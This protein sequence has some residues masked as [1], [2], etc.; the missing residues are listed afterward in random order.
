MEDKYEGLVKGGQGKDSG[1]VVQSAF[2][3]AGCVVSILLIIAI[4]G[5]FF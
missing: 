3:F 1:E 5:L 2:V 4:R